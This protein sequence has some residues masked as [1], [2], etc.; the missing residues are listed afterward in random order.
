MNVVLEQDLGAATHGYAA[1][2]DDE[3]SI[4][5]S[6]PLPNNEISPMGCLSCQAALAYNLHLAYNFLK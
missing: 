1:G 3:P 6:F 5:Q 2:A 4:L